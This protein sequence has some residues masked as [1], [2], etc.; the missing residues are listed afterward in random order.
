M[1]LGKR[2]LLVIFPVILIIQLVASTTAYL[3]QRASLLGLEQARLEQQLSAL[4]SAYLDYEAF[5]RSV[6]YSIIDS[7]ALLHFLR[8]SDTA[9][10]NDTLGLRLQQSIR[11]LSNTELS[12]VSFAIVQPDGQPAYYFESSLSPFGS[13]DATQQ[14]IVQQARQS[15]SSATIYLEQAD[16]APLLVNTDF[17]LPA[18]GSRPLPSQR[19]EAFAIQL[20]V[21]PERFIKLK[22]AL[23]SEYG[24]PVEIADQQLPMDVGLSAEIR[25]RAHCTPA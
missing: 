7:E 14:R 24:A 20:A 6:L 25:C 23:E 21:R 4:K 10:R 15:A 2:A 18:S 16:G 3:T 19:G 11:S 8:E 9:F 12:F 17:V 5:N 1:T 22:R 13:M